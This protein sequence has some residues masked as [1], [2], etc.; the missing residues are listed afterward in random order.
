M[1]KSY[2]LSL[3]WADNDEDDDDHNDKD[4]HNNGDKDNHNKGLED[5]TR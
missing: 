4:N 3:G 1:S 2:N 5:W